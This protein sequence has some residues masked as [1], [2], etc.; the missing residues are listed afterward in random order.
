MIKRFAVH[1]HIGVGRFLPEIVGDL[2]AHSDAPGID[3][4][5]GFA[6]AAVAEVGEKLVEPTH[7]AGNLPGAPG[8]AMKRNPG[9]FV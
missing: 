8:K 1:A 3:P 6:T 7:R 5:A 2:A 4:G 9:I